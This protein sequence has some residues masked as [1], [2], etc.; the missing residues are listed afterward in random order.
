VLRILQ[1][2]LAASNVR[3]ATE[4]RAYICACASARKFPNQALVLEFVAG[5][6]PGLCLQAL[7]DKGL[8][9]ADMNA[10]FQL[11]SDRVVI[12][13]ERCCTGRGWPSLS[14]LFL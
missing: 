10:A 11:K 4:T 12:S 14:A 5:G 8:L 2:V 7:Q 13:I 1:T 6:S 9:L 3:M